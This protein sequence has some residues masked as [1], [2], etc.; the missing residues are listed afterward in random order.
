MH[1]RFEAIDYGRG[2]IA[3]SIPQISSTLSQRPFIVIALQII[4][5]TP[6]L[7]ESAGREIAG[8]GIGKR[9]ILPI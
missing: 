2:I 9:S 3:P 5:R 8:R 6:C 4:P 1:D 7:P